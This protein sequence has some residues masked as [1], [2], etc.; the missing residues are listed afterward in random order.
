MGALAKRLLSDQSGA[1]APVFALALPML[2]VAGG[3][4]FDYAR[5][6]A[7]DSELQNAADQAALAAASQLDGLPGACLRANAVIRSLA[8]G[9]MVEND[10]LFAN[11]VGGNRVVTIADEPSCDQTGNVR[12][13]STAGRVAAGTDAAA[14]FIEVTIS[15][16]TARYALT[17]VVGIFNSGAIAA[18]AL[19]GLGSAICKVPPLMMCN[20]DEASGSLDFNANG[21][22]GSGMLLVEGGGG[23]WKAG[24]FGFLQTGL[25]NGAAALEYALGA[26]A[27]LGNCIRADSVTTKPGENTSV[28]DAINTRFDIFENGLTADCAESDG[29]CSPALNTR[30]DVVRPEITAGGRPGAGGGNALNCGFKTGTDPW[31]LPPSAFRYLP[32]PTTGV[33]S[34]LPYNMGLP[35][36]I[37]HAKSMDGSCTGGRLGDA[38]WD[39]ATYL[40]VN[41]SAAGSVTA[42]SNW[43]TANSVTW[44]NISRYDMYQAEIATGLTGGR[45]AYTAG[46]PGN[47][48]TTTYY[49]Y[50]APKC[51][52]GLPPSSTQ[53][54]RRLTAIAVVNCQDQGVNGSAKGISVSKWVEIFLVEPSISRD[55]TRAGDIYV[56]IIKEISVGNADSS[57]GQVTR[58]DVPY[59][60][61]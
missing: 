24:N 29:K 22:K 25:A 57:G 28:T 19:A 30:K 7:M 40:A 11:E 6:A 12:F 9:G 4:S 32:D 8:A 15:A 36:D 27:P 44:A 33:Q 35:R 37:C 10:T 14:K 18:T 1:I 52:P 53:L 41:H 42:L 49:S 58:R 50:S 45:S 51:T 46:G 60:V 59:L 34:V 55:R 31:D 23:Q 54:D 43:A 61:E 38:S 20:P 47:G 21:R 39:R 26:N 3:V 13:Y 48:N 17:P 5:L 16:R 2:I 56:E